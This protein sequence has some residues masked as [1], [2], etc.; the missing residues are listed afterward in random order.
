MYTK[1]LLLTQLTDAFRG[2]LKLHEDLM[3]WLDDFGM[4]L[5][6]DQFD[7]LAQYLNLLKQKNDVL[8]LTR[9]TD[10]REMWIK[11]IFDGLMA[12]PFIARTPGAKVMDLGSGGGI[13]GIPLA[14]VFP[15]AQFTLVD[16]VQ[17]KT[18]ALREFIEELN[19]KNVQ[20]IASRIEVL[21]QQSA[22]REQCDVVT[23]RALAPLRVLAEL[24]V[25]LIHP[26]GHVVAYK[27]P[28]YIHELSDAKHALSQLKAEKPKVYHYGLPE[29]QGE[30][31]LMVL[32]K[33]WPTPLK[34]P[35]REG[36]P[37]KN[38]L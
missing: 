22:H 15:S 7:K 10:L 16:S 37:K 32:T 9:I 18:S 38:P 26:Y 1:P 14:I 13:P 29:E 27:G 33:K 2:M 35:R 20:V 3:G 21:G 25:P 4:Q 31:T 23:A 12:A 17:K 24:A 5:T 30:R 6:E 11:H 28:D 8:N 19:L 36:M 34:Y